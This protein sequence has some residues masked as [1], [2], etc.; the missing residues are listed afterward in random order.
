MLAPETLQAVLRRLKRGPIVGADAGTAVA[1]GDDVLD[2]LLPHR[3]PMRLVDGI[4]RVDV[5]ASAVDRAH[6]AVDVPG[7]L[8]GVEQLR[9]GLLARTHERRQVLRRGR[10]APG[11]EQHEAEGWTHVVPPLVS[12]ALVQVVHEHAV[13]HRQQAGDRDRWARVGAHCAHGGVNGSPSPTRA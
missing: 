6:P 10:L 11:G 8:H 2:R 12:Q 7:R 4:D 13:G 5:A 9:G 1:Y 3:R